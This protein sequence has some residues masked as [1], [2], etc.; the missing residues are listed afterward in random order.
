MRTITYF[1][2]VV[3]NKAGE[4]AKVLAG[5]KAAGINLTA[6]WGYP[7]KG[8]KAVLELAPED[9][10]AYV[11]AAKKAGLAPGAKKV[12]FYFDGEDRPGALADVMAKLAAAG[13][14]VA[15]SLAI[16]AGAGRYGA[17]IQVDLKDVGKA[18]KVLSKA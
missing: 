5:L 10:K 15:A 12:A 17:L 2:V 11:Q 14:S 18:R 4:A 1:S 3:P 13:I 16:C 9:A 6:F 7:V 8:R